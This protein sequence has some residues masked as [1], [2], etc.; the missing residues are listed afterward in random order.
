MPAKATSLA[1]M[2]WT[3]PTSVPWPSSAIICTE[4]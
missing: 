2:L 3:P 1:A 4:Y